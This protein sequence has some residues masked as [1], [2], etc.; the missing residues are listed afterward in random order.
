MKTSDFFY[1]ANNIFYSLHTIPRHT[2]LHVNTKGQL[3]VVKSYLGQWGFRE[4]GC[5]CFLGSTSMIF[6]LSTMVEGK[7]SLANVFKTTVIRLSSSYQF[8]DNF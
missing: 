4:C 5:F 2:E 7:D 8:F 1:F 3:I 6:P